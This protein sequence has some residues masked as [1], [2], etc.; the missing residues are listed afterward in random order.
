[1]STKVRVDTLERKLNQLSKQYIQQQKSARDLIEADQSDILSCL[2]DGV[3]SVKATI[4]DIR[5]PQSRT[6][7]FE[8]D[9]LISFDVD[10]IDHYKMPGSFVTELEIPDESIVPRTRD[11][12]VLRER[13]TAINKSFTNL[14]SSAD[15][16]LEDVME[17]QLA[18]TTFEDQ[19]DNLQEEVNSTMQS[20]QSAVASTQESLKFKKVKKEG[21]QSRLS[22]VA[23][24]LSGVEEDISDNKDHRKIAKV[25]KYGALAV[26]PFFLPAL[27][28]A[29]GMQVGGMVLKDKKQDLIKQRS[30]VNTEFEAVKSEIS[31]LEKQNIELEAALQGNKKLST[32]CGKLT[33]QAKFSKKELVCKADE[34]QALKEAAG[35]FLLWSETL[36]HRAE[37][38]EDFD[39]GEHL[40]QMAL[41]LVDDLAKCKQREVNAICQPLQALLLGGRSARGGRGGELSLIDM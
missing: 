16:Q 25:V 39:D 24:E 34:Y 18:V 32:R 10:P 14:A 31:S 28:I 27:G 23:S 9:A 33:Q 7:E 41:R 4:Q 21:A 3:T 37:L 17:I 40:D 36:Q 1:M 38:M 22:T 13:C 20:A 8:D 5:A 26:S 12:V 30:R 11:L 19:L 2:R 29:A 35:S 6:M 15:K